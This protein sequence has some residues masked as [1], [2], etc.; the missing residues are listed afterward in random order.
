VLEE[1]Y[2]IVLYQSLVL[3]VGMDSILCNK[4]LVDY[5]SNDIIETMHPN[6]PSR[7]IISDLSQTLTLCDSDGKNHHHEEELLQLR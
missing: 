5:A 4:S 6:P 3:L 7:F 1:S 2:P